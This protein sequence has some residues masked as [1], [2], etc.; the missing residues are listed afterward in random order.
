MREVAFIL[1]VIVILLGLT[2]LR[3]R[4]QISA[5]LSF[6]KMLSDARENARGPRTV[7]A[8]PEKKGELVA[9]TRCGTWTPK[10]NAIRFDAATYYCSKDCVRAALTH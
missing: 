2:A 1:F 10:N 5:L 3:Y 8:V 6:G 9:C 7:P 4:K